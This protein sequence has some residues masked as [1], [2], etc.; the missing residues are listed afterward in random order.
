MREA[1][2]PAVGRGGRRRYGTGGREGESSRIYGAAALPPF[3]L[4]SQRKKTVL[5]DISVSRPS[6]HFRTLFFSH[7]SSFPFIRKN[8]PIIL[9][10]LG[11]AAAEDRAAPCLFCGIISRAVS[12]PSFLFPSRSHRTGAEG[13]RDRDWRREKEKRGRERARLCFVLRN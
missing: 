2:F 9:D 10:R 6:W 7:S 1:T 12:S 13:G 4:R 5:P 11:S 8:P 3:R